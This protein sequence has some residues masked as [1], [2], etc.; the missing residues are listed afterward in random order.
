[1]VLSDRLSVFRANWLRLGEVE[2]IGDGDPRGIICHAEVIEIAVEIIRRKGRGAEIAVAIFES[3]RP[4]VG[5]GV[6]DARAKR[7][8]WPRL[9]KRLPERV[10]KKIGERRAAGHVKQCP[11]GS[12]AGPAAKR[13][14]HV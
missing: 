6:F 12:D 1:M 2:A 10:C 5:D 11:F 3:G 9:A 7:P 8:A 13:R 14:P 4:L